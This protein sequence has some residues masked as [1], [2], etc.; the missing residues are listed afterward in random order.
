MQGE[1]T[2]ILKRLGAGEAGAAE[3][4]FG[5]LYP[6]LREIAGRVFRS[7]RKNHT[8]QPTALV[9][10]A[11]LKMARPAEGNPEFADRSHFLAV[12]ATAMRQILVNHARDRGAMKRGGGVDR[13]RVTLAGVIRSDRDPVDVLTVDEVLRELAALNERQARIAELRFF[14]GLTNPE[15]AAALEVSLRTVELDWKMAKTWLAER[16]GPTEEEP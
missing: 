15:I 14:G 8:L 5:R 16:L 13:Q 7:Q 10:E 4:L 6:E 3:E 2:Q 1:L 11:W 12:A 9:G